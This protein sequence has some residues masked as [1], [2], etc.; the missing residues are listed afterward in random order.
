[1]DSF[2][3]YFSIIVRVCKRMQSISTVDSVGVAVA[4]VT[5]LEFNF[6]GACT[7]LAWIEPSVINKILWS[8]LPHNGN[9]TALVISQWKSTPITI[10][11]FLVLMPWGFEYLCGAMTALYGMS[12]FTSLN[13]Q[14][15]K[16]SCKLLPKQNSSLIKNKSNVPGANLEKLEVKSDTTEA[17]V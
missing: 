5:D 13:L 15:A 11:F 4:T 7:A 3:R 9:W 12:V 1:I 14:E 6:F 16:E 2:V 10:F 17:V 8:N